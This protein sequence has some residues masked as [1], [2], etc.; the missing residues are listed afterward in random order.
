ML[1]ECKPSLFER[2]RSLWGNMGLHLAVESILGGKTA[3][4]MFVD[5][6]LEPH[7][8]MMWT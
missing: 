6:V 4:R 3:A 1:F 8:A 5:D 2:T 7:A